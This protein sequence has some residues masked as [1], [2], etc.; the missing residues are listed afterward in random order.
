[1][2]FVRIN[3]KLSCNRKIKIWN[4]FFKNNWAYGG[5]NLMWL[6][7]KHHFH[8]RINIV[9]DMICR[10][11]GGIFATHFRS[12]FVHPWIPRHELLKVMRHLHWRGSIARKWIHEHIL[13]IFKQ[14]TRDFVTWCCFHSAVCRKLLLEDVFQEM[15]ST[16]GSLKTAIRACWPVR[17]SSVNLKIFLRI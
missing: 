3:L 11:I 9:S 7:N 16:E 4:S 8:L 17:H 2:Y 13:S 15:L 6:T 12:Y 14:S 5:S 1:M 10:T